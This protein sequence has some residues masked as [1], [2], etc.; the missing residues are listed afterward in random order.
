MSEDDL[1]GP[2]EPLDIYDLPDRD[3]HHLHQLLLEHLADYLGGHA[4]GET[5]QEAFNDCEGLQEEFCGW[6]VEKFFEER[7]A[8]L[9]RW[10]E[11]FRRELAEDAKAR[12]ESK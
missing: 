2:R 10:E 7:E 9:K 11:N 3:R 8:T 12:E 5:E 4:A 6:L 1:M